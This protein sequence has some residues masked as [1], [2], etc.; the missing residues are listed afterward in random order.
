MQL[1]G[2]LE[3]T[4]TRITERLED[5]SGLVEKTIDRFNVDMDRMLHSRE[6]ML[7]GL[8]ASLGKKAQE[9]DTMMRNYMGM[10][11]DFWPPRSRAPRRS[12]AISHRNTQRLRV[13]SNRS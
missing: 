8:V 6:D 5:V 7:S 2:R 11:E 4:G 13:G 3:T 9:V 1:T 10:I 12:A